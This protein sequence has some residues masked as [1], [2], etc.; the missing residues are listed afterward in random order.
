MNFLIARGQFIIITESQHDD[1][2]NCDKQQK[3]RNK[4]LLIINE[5]RTRRDEL[6]ASGWMQWPVQKTAGA[7][8]VQCRPFAF[9]LYILANLSRLLDR[10]GCA[11][12]VVKRVFTH[13]RSIGGHKLVPRCNIAIP[14]STSILSHSMPGVMTPKETK[15]MIINRCIPPTDADAAL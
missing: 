7:S 12:K 5:R 14:I 4:S 2:C 15:A 9:N 3:A 11:P 1:N 6:L 8:S 13:L 10:T